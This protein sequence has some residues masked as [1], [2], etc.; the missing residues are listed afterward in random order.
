MILVTCLIG[1]TI[2]VEPHVEKDIW[3]APQFPEWPSG[4]GIWYDTPADAKCMARDTM[5]MLGEGKWLPKRR[6][7]AT[8]RLIV[9][10]IEMP[11]LMQRQ[12]DRIRLELV[13]DFVDAAVDEAVARDRAQ[14]AVEQESGWFLSGLALTVAIVV[15]V[16]SFAGGALLGGY[17]VSH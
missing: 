3:T 4:L 12:L 15:G 16:L 1:S 5:Q 17:V 9:N 14:T 11:G 7:D 6:A 2:E 10:C 13:P 8:A